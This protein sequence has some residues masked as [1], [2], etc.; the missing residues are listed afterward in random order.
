M[1]RG[2]NV[3]AVLWLIYKLEQEAEKK[4]GKV[5]F[6]LGN[7]E[8]MNLNYEAYYAQSKYKA[9]AQK[10]SGISKYNDAYAVFMSNE[11]ELVKWLKSKNIILKLGEYLFVHGGISSDF[12]NEFSPS[13]EAINTVFHKRI[14]DRNFQQTAFSRSIFGNKGPFWYR[15]NVMDYKEMY[16][17]EN[18]KDFQSILTHFKVKK[19][20]IGHTVVES[21][22]S[23]YQGKLIR[24]DVKHGKGK[25]SSLSE[26]VLIENNK[27]LIIN[28]LGEKKGID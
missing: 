10:I 18:E 17:K 12:I 2:K 26:C 22:S 9:F 21:I 14:L 24:L 3:T 7:H 8:I 15:G 16:L 11:N 4:G 19:I 6:V 13:I 20:V 28:G 23:D 25:N 5:H 1:D 27:T